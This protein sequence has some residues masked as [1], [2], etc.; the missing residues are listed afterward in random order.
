MR[1]LAVLATGGV[2]VALSLGFAAPLASAA[3]GVADQFGFHAVRSGIPAGAGHFSLTSPDLQD[4]HPF[5]Q[6]E[7][8]TA[9]NGGNQAPRLQWSGAPAATQSFA[10]TM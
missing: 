6:S 8:G 7:I 3:Q 5:P 10:L 1:L 4:N 9:C 2:V